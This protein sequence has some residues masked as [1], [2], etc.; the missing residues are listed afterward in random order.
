LEVI[1]AEKSQV[2]RSKVEGQGKREKHPEALN[3]KH[4]IR[5]EEYK[6]VASS[7]ASSVSMSSDFS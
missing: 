7:L 6:E 5:N 4:E 1:G 2:L 3:F